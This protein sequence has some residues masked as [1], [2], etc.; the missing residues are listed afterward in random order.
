MSG[1]VDMIKVFKG[2]ISKEDCQTVVNL[3]EKADFN[4]M[5]RFET[6]FWKNRILASKAMP[7]EITEIINKVL[8]ET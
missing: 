2:A 1:S 8:M 3:L 7:K 4:Y 6:D 5:D